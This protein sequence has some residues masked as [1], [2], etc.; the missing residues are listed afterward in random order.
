[1]SRDVLIVSV[2]P[3]NT[4]RPTVRPTRPT[5]PT[6][7]LRILQARLIENLSPMEKAAVQSISN[8]VEAYSGFEQYLAK[9][10]LAKYALLP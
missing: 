9:K 6:E 2:P 8:L 3:G 5:T 1:M 7:R 10:G 4:T